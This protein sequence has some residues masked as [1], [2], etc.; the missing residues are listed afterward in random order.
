MAGD[1][2]AAEKTMSLATHWDRQYQGCRPI[3][4]SDRPTTEV[5]HTVEH[6]GIR[7]CR[8]LELGCG[9]GTNAVWLAR[10]G[11]AVT[12]IDVSPAAILRARDRAVRA[13]VAV[14]FLLGDLREMRPRGGPY[15]F[16][17]DCGCY[18]AVQLGDAPGYVEALRRLTRPGSLGLVLTGNDREPE[19]PEGPPAL[20]DQ[21]L[22]HDVEEFFEIVRLREFRFD[23]DQGNG[24]RYLGWSCLLRRLAGEHG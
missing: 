7:P 9:T 11:F 1:E 21:R 12:A 8:M 15:D 10:R 6:E 17:L 2:P 20:S 24:K 23:A 14:R 18:G 19:D 5:V 13:N 22:R 16:F 3:W 4:D